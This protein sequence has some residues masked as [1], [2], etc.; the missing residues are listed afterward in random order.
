MNADVQVALNKVCCQGEEIEVD[1]IGSVVACEELEKI[2]KNNIYL[3]YEN[4]DIYRASITVGNGVSF[5][6]ATHFI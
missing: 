4:N 1:S 2:N 5:H 3:F 6:I